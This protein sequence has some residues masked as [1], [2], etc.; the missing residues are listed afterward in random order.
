MFREQ[1]ERKTRKGVNQIASKL[2]PTLASTL[3]YQ[4]ANEISKR[5]ISACGETNVERGKVHTR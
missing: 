5:F 3:K 4:N 1:E 2:P